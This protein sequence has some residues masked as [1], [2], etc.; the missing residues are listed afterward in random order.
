MAFDR[1]KLSGNMGAG[2]L[3]PKVYTFKDDAST[4]VEI[5]TADYFLDVYQILDV[6][7]VINAT[8]S[9]GTTNLAVTASSITT[10]TVGDV[11]PSGGVATFTGAVTSITITNGIVTAIS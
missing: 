8:G 10:V 7:D 4:M 11:V 1:K 5:A 9:D 6:G 2:S 3:A